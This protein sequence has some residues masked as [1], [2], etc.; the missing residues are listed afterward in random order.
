MSLSQVKPYFRT[1]IDTV[2]S[3]LKEWTKRFDTKNI[4][5]NIYNKSYVIKLGNL[6]SRPLNDL[7]VEDEFN[8]NIV[9]YYKAIRDYEAQKDAI[10]DK[11]HDIRIEA[12][13]PINS[14]VGTNIKNIVLNEIL[15]E[16]ID[17]NDNS[18][19]LTMDF[20]VSLIFSGR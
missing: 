4:P 20:S 3:E 12:V 9:L 10:Y 7:I 1:I 15:L 2:D 18:L 13:K 19:I 8:V 17:E 11:A 5:K 14:M 16:E 6:L